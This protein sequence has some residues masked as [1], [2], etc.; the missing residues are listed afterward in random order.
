MRQSPQIDAV[1]ARET[2]DAAEMSK[3]LAKIHNAAMGGDRSCTVHLHSES[4]VQDLR[5]R[6]FD[7]EEPAKHV[8]LGTYEVRWLKL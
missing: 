3:A 5:D 1:W 2:S 6:G 8:A 4:A 7:V